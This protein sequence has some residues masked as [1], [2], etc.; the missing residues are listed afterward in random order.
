MKV[1]VVK[2]ESGKVVATFEAAYGGS[3]ATVTPVLPHGHR[4]EEVEVEESYREIPSAL[5]SETG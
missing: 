5:Y 4:V 3:D 2:D 1:K